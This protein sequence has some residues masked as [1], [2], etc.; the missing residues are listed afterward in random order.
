MRGLGGIG[1]RGAGHPYKSA[2]YLNAFWKGSSMECISDEN[3]WE[4]MRS[5]VLIIILYD[6]CTL[7]YMYKENLYQSLRSVK[8]VR[9]FMLIR[10]TDKLLNIYIVTSYKYMHASR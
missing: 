6:I 9:N 5:N 2:K 8:C 1:M 3:H 7:P 10:A 4:R